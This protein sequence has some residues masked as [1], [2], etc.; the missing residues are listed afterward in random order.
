MSGICNPTDVL[1]H[2]GDALISIGLNHEIL[3]M[4]PVAEALTGYSEK[5]ALGRPCH[6]VLNAGLQGRAGS[7]RAR[8]HQLPAT[9]FLT[10]VCKDGCPFRLTLEQ[11]EQVTT[12]D[13]LLTRRSGGHV[14]VCINTSVL[15]NAAGEKIG[16]VEDIRDIRHV[17]RLIAEREQALQESNRLASHLTALLEGMSE[18]VVSAD[19]NC[20]ITGFNRAAGELL[21][22]SRRE[23]IGRTC[24]ELFGGEFCPIQMT[25]ETGRGLPG[26]E[27]M[28]RARDASRLPVWLTTAFLHD[29]RGQPR[30]VVATF[31][32]LR[33]TQRLKEQVRDRYHFDTLI[34]KSAAM[35]RIYERLQ[36]V[37]PSDATVLITG[38]SGTGKE[39][40]AGILHAHS[41]RW[42]QP[43]IRVSCAALPETLLETE[44]FGHVRGAFTGAIADKAGRFELAHR[45]TILLDEI[46]ELTPALQAKLL[47]VLQEREFERVGSTRTVR[48]DVR[49][50]AATNR[51]PEKMMAAGSFREDLFYRLNVVP[52]HIP[53]LRDHPE[54]IPLLAEHFLGR[55]AARSE[56]ASKRLTPEALRLLMTHPWPGNVRELENAMEYA[57][58][59]ALDGWLRPEA[60]PERVGQPREP[61]LLSSS[62]AQAERN[63]ILQALASAGS[64]TAAARELHISRPTLWRKMKKLSIERAGR[65]FQK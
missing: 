49:V 20:V 41:P 54:D 1:R 52:I 28:L 29:D 57:A 17:L 37:A 50:I 40:V 32:D 21:G 2:T 48:V 56:T 64:L 8:N 27:I 35:Q 65:T 13:T 44:M 5:D 58:L 53:P 51:D 60:L 36:Q 33:E 9:R 38:E 26:S 18:G 25:L 3:S 4:N 7:R 39:L 19:L 47:R 45:G 11:E 10:R 62:L 6:E 55:A 15:K 24:R 46:S 63:L 22:Y 43:F 59:T 42:N 16:I 23:A 12:F 61:A 14:H 31:A 34:G 30:G